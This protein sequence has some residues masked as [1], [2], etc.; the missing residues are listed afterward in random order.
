[1]AEEIRKFLDSPGVAGVAIERTTEK[2]LGGTISVIKD[3]IPKDLSKT[4][5]K[6]RIEYRKR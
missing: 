1:M 6:M 5:P 4:S 2:M 3:K